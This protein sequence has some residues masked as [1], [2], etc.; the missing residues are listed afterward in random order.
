MKAAIL[1][2]HGEADQ[3]ELG[4]WPDPV[5]GPGDVVIEVR[6]ASLN[7]RDWWIMRNPARGAAPCILGSDAAGRRAR[8]RAR[9]SRGGAPGDEVLLYPALGWGDREDAPT[10]DFEIFGMP[11]QGVFA[12]Q[13][14]VPAECVSRKA[15]APLVRRGRRASASP[16][17][18]R[19]AALLTRGGVRRGLDGARHRAAAAPARSRSRSRP[20]SAP[21]ST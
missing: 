21:A 16:G 19:G 14:V 5:A 1:R 9:A 11:R 2:A 4:D 10:A 6:A 13:V 3:I 12:E 18:R 20:R 8:G 7:R 17:S 15:G